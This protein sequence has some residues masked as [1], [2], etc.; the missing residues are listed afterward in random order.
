MPQ[1]LPIIGA[2]YYRVDIENKVAYSMR[3]GILNPMKF[4]TKYMTSTLHID[5]KIIGTTLYRMM[6]CAQNH[7]DITKIPSDI[8]ISMRGGKLQVMD[9]S[10]VNRNDSRTRERKEHQ[11]ERAKKNLELIQKYYAGDVSPLLRYLKRIE[12]DVTNEYMFMYGLCKERAQIVSGNAINQYLDELK[13][14][15]AS[16]YI[17]TY[18]FKIARRHNANIRRNRVFIDNMEVIEI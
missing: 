1:L 9:R 18:I 10:G 17:K 15:T 3:N 8:C 13:R 4:R 11:L 7:I 5:G 6:Y 14:G 16:F 2:P 12:D